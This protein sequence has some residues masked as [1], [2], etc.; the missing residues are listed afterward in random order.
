MNHHEEAPKLSKLPFIAGDIL[1]VATAVLIATRSDTPLGS[2]ALIA[3]TVC[4]VLGAALLVIPFLAD[5][6][7]RADAELADR[8]NQIAA[9][10][11]TTSDSAEQLGIVASGLGFF[12][13]NIGAT[14]VGVGRLA[15]MNN[16]KVPLMISVSLLVFGER[17]NLASLGAS[18]A[19]MAAAVWL[20]EKRPA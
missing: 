3:I 20:A 14:R 7:R 9:L 6:A 15:V 13:W 5:Y 16:A 8:Q 11:R 10:A 1:L 19:L 17:T 12:L 4:V 2:G 18:F